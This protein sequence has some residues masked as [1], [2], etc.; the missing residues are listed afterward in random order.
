M[1]NK[2]VCKKCFHVLGLQWIKNDEKRW[3]HD[4]KVMCMEN[5]GN[6]FA[7]ITKPPHKNCLYILEQIVL[8]EE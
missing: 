6:I 8:N 5:I 2:K 1:L 3:K 4:N 7:D